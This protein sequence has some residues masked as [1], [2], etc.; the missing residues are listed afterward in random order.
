MLL[1]LLAK[2]FQMGRARQDTHAA[3]LLFAYA[4]KRVVL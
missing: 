4:W 3:C 1:A 2:W